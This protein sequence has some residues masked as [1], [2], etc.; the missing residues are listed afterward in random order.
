MTWREARFGLQNRGTAPQIRNQHISRHFPSIQHRFSM[1]SKRLSRPGCLSFLHA[2]NLFTP[3][4]GFMRADRHLA[5]AGVLIV[6]L[7]CSPG[8]SAAQGNAVTA[9]N[10]VATTAVLI[11]P[12]R[13]LDS[14]AMAAVHAAIS[15]H[16][17]SPLPAV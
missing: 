6:L 7:L 11:N 12:G 13:I 8:T 2:Q 5:I 17:R 3:D 14:R 4:G 16:R 10:S 15:L 1:A 9:W